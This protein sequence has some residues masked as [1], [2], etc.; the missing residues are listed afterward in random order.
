VSNWKKEEEEERLREKRVC[1][2]MREMRELKEERVRRKESK[3]KI[4]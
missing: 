1:Y 3:G 4:E 2:K